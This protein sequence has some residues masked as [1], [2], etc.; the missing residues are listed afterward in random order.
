VVLS[1]LEMSFFSIVCLEAL[2]MYLH[3]LL[4]VCL[5]VCLLLEHGFPSVVAASL[6]AIVEG[7]QLMYVKM[8]CTACACMFETDVLHHFCMTPAECSE[9]STLYLSIFVGH[10]GVFQEIYG[11]G[12][13]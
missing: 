2:A 4:F 10:I 11:L 5:F 1:A 7:S 3:K 9:T 6:F 13:T 8:Y 12:G